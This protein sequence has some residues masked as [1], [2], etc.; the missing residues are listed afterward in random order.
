MCVIKHSVVE[1]REYCIYSTSV[2]SFMDY[3]LS[4]LFRWN[5]FIYFTVCSGLGDIPNGTV[6]SN[7]SHYQSVATYSCDLGYTLVGNKTRICQA[8]KT[9]SFK[10]PNC[11]INS[12]YYKHTGNL[13][14]KRAFTG[15]T[16]ICQKWI[17]FRMH[18]FL[19]QFH[20]WKL[21]HWSWALF[22]S[23][24]TNFIFYKTVLQI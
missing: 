7:G 19:P 21:A 3:F 12:K 4:F 10:T 11:T 13:Y 8:D 23:C 9:W 6:A 18:I 24:V 20:L 14:I 2:I 15:L 5:R 17:F 22:L 16:D 1:L